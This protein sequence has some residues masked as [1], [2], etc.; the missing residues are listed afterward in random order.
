MVPMINLWAVASGARIEQQECGPEHPCGTWTVIV[1]SVRLPVP[2][3]R[4]AGDGQQG[5]PGARLP[6]PLVVRVADEDDCAMSGVAV[7]FSVTR[8]GGTL[9]ADA[10]RVTTVT[11][12]DGL[13]R[14]AWTLGPT[15]P[16]EAQ[17]RVVNGTREPVAFT[18][19]VP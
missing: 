19:A 18:A 13:A 1:Q 9:T 10:A 8:G 14:A 5:A 6:D 17:A 16:Q 11:D 4:H 15:G 12:T 7:E 2:I 3:H